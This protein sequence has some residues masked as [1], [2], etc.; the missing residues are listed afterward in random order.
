MGACGYYLTDRAVFLFAAVLGIPAMA[1]LR[2]LRDAD[3]ASPRPCRQALIPPAGPGDRSWLFIAD[4][5]LITF[6]GC[7][8]LFHL[9]NA[10]MLPIAAAAVTKRAGSEAALVITACIVGP[11]IVTRVGLPVGRVGRRD[12]GPAANPRSGLRD[13]ADPQHIARRRR[14]SQSSFSTGSA[15]RRLACCFR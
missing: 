3:H 1:A 4:R 15:R 13:P 5:R 11:Q 6:G 7:A 9:A 14:R 10:A 2:S 12:L 8:A